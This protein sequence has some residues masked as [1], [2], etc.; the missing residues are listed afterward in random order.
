MIERSIGQAVLL[1]AL[2]SC[3]APAA[4][5]TVTS[6]KA[7]EQGAI[8]LR[9][10]FPNATTIGEQAPVLRLPD[11]GQVLI[12]RSIRFEPRSPDTPLRN[13]FRCAVVI[14]G[15]G[16]RQAIVTI[17]E[18][19]TETLSC[20]DFIEG[21]LVPN[22]NGTARLVLI[23]ATRSPNAEGRTAVILTRRLNTPAWSVD[24]RVMERL[25]EA[26]EPASVKSVKAA[27]LA[28]S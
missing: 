18:G 20:D 3:Q 21:D 4:E 2:I 15:G 10:L 17:G 25:S 28:D 19:W 11:A 9:R 24:E 1:A 23:Y 5:T 26:S 22:R 27:L 13:A 8:D 6:P 16:A 12:V 14:E 7:A